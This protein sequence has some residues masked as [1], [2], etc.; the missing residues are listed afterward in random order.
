MRFEIKDKGKPST[1]QI[2][3]HKISLKL[4]ERVCLL[5]KNTDKKEEISERK[6]NIKKG[7]GIWPLV[8]CT[9]S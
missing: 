3:L 9:I 5:Q 4:E 8:F 1:M 6:V 2:I 7:F